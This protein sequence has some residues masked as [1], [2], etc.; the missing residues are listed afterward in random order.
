MGEPPISITMEIRVFDR[1]AETRVYDVTAS[2]SGVEIFGIRFGFSSRDLARKASK[3]LAGCIG[4]LCGRKRW[5]AGIDVLTPG[6]FG[7]FPSFHGERVVK[8]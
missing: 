5:N 7:E 1:T 8:C 6:V 2:V 3:L 4:V